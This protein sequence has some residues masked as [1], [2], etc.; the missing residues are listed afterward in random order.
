[1][2]RVGASARIRDLNLASLTHQQ[3]AS[4]PSRRSAHRHDL[5]PNFSHGLLTIIERQSGGEWKEK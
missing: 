1:M 3:V 2:R 4:S 5:E